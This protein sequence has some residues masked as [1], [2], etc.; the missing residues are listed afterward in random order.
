M[1]DIFLKPSGVK[2]FLPSTVRKKRIVEK[3]FNE[4]FRKWGYE[5]VITPS[6]E[7]L[8]TFVLDEQANSDNIFKFFDRNGK[9]M[10]LRPDVTKSIARMAAT[11]YSDNSMPLRFCYISN[12]FRFQ[13]PRMGHDQEFFQVGAELIG[14]DGIEGDVEAILLASNLLKKVGIDD[15]I[16]NIGHIRFLE[17]LLDDLELN[18]DIRQKVIQT[19]WEKNF[20]LLEELLK[21]I[22]TSKNKIKE[23]LLSLNKF[24]GG[25]QM[26]HELMKFPLND[27]AKGSLTQI[28]ELAEMI[29]A[30][31]NV[32]L[33]FDPGLIKSQDY[34][35]GI[36]FEI[37]SPK[38]GFPL[39]SGGRYDNLL[40][41]FDG[42]RPATGFALVEE[43]LLSLLE[44][45]IVDSY[46]PCYVLYD[47]QSFIQAFKK[48][49]ELKNQDKI[50][51][52][53]PFKREFLDKIKSRDKKCNICIFC[54]GKLLEK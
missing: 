26:L 40:N 15:F 9:V 6:F 52:L 38:A 1:N 8:K 54:N 35:T 44:R 24:Y 39:G 43:A 50:V 29:K 37:Y 21:G 3:Q 23:I 41:K 49:E 36:N 53:T 16:I 20:V 19:I 18:L 45:S 28:I 51:K 33:T 13:E 31:S 42:S 34:Y 48:A 46:E 30:C 2:D 4:V 10:A 22:D 5:E 17:G 27:K 47:K 7:N 11:Y 32:T 12:V 14:I 25:I